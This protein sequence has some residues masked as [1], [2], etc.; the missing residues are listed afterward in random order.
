[1]VTQQPATT[2]AEAP[3]PLLGAGPL[4]PG[5]S[6]IDTTTGQV[7]E[8]PPLSHDQL[9][10][11]AY[12]ELF[13]DFGSRVDP[14][15]GKQVFFQPATTLP[16]T[17]ERV[18]EQFGDG[19]ADEPPDPIEAWELRLGGSKFI[20]PPVNINVSTSYRAGSLS[21]GALRQPYSR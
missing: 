19:R 4:L 18:K 6:R 17:E 11:I 9:L 10:A 3:P 13:K 16:T 7:T 15:T 14:A 2:P 8:G 1:M 5:Q 20:V 21:G 12:Q